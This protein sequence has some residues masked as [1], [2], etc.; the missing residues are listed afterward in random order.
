[1]K[2]F[3]EKVATFGAVL[4]GLILALARYKQVKKQRNKAR[5]K[6]INLEAQAAERAD[7]EKIEA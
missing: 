4:A 6:V 5:Q 7:F 3:T 2:W 1:M